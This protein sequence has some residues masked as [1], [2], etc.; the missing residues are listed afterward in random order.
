MNDASRWRLEVARFVAP[1]IAK[2]PKVQAIVLGGS[3]SRGHADSYSDI[4]IGVFW[5]EPPTDAERI[6]PIEPAGGV[7]WELD[8]YDPIEDTWMDE[9]GLGGV[10]MDVRNLTVAGLERILAEVTQQADTVEFKHMT[11]SAIQYGM[12]LYNPQMLEQ[13]QAQ[14][15]P[16]PGALGRAL[17]QKNLRLDSWCWWVELLAQRGDLTLMYSSLSQGA[18]KMLYMLT[19]LNQ[20]YFPGFKWL[21][22]LMDDL[23]IKPE[24]L[25][26][27]MTQAFQSEPLTATSTLR[28]LIV[29]TYDLIEAHMPDVDTIEARS[30]FLKQ[31]PQ[32]A[33][34]PEGILP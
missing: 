12:A 21:Y 25:S 18:H 20:M 27:R 1:I 2:N 13:W 3:A 30:E 31:R 16:Y 29:E 10:K 11:V 19:G 8:P 17:I 5:S 14:L 7:F 4:E 34:L 32:V 24:H 9:W 22:R 33:A 6:A 23:A 15:T 28:D 26:A